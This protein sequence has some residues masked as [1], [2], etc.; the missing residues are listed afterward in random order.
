MITR[1]ESDYLY[2]NEIECLTRNRNWKALEKSMAKCKRLSNCPLHESSRNIDC[3]EQHN[4]LH[5]VLKYNAPFNIIRQIVAINPELV[6]QTNSI[7]HL[8]LHTALTSGT[9]PSVVKHLYE[10]NEKSI[11]IVDEE[12][13]T[14]LHLAFEAY[15][16]VGRS[17]LTS[18]KIAEVIFL[19][20][21]LKP[22]NML[23]M[24]ENSMDVLEYALE[25]EAPYGLI[26]KLQRI[27]VS[28]RKKES[29]PDDK[30]DYMK[31]CEKQKSKGGNLKKLLGSRRIKKK[32]INMGTA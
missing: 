17:L 25:K 27:A 10:A 1:Q 11:S 31:I 23:V 28:L 26:K 24:D 2:A 30:K 13:K 16:K 21:S 4:I 18:S 19:V 3:S 8:P 15:E 20:L 14:P 32:I 22:S 29:C 7:G 5:F 9:C 12:G 6:Y